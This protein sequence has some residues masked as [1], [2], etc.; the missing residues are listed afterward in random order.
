MASGAA[1]SGIWCVIEVWQA[2]QLVDR[3]TCADLRSIGLSVG[4]IGDGLIVRYPAG[5]SGERS[6]YV[7]PWPLPDEDRGVLGQRSRLDPLG[8]RDG[9]VVPITRA[10]ASMLG[11]AE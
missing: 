8:L 5:A 9:V 3:L 4:G 2:D 11:D 1:L 10:E 7:S 6:V